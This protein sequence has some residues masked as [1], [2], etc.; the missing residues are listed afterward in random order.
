MELGAWV[1]DINVDLGRDSQLQRVRI[2]TRETRDAVE[3]LLDIQLT[4]HRREYYYNPDKAYYTYIFRP[5]TVDDYSGH[6]SGGTR[7][8]FGLDQDYDKTPRLTRNGMK[9][10]WKLRKR[11]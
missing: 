3:K 2:A 10:F 4:G 6:K 11:R 1:A 8:L 5:E 7:F 9:S